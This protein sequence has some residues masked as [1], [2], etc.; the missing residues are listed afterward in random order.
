MEMQC[1]DV[2]FHKD[3]WGPQS[4]LVTSWSLAEKF[5]QSF[6]KEVG[7]NGICETSIS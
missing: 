1:G 2:K 3:I 6:F 5:I 7:M 4:E